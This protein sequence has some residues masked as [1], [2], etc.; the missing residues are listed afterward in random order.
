M[1]ENKR[2]SGIALI[3]VLALMA[4]LGVLAASAVAISSYAA[5]ETDTFT[6]LQR[7]IL[8]AE[9]VAN[10]TLFL[11]LSDRAKYADR[12]LGE[13]EVSAGPRFLADGTKHEFIVND[14]P[15]TVRIF[16]ATSGVDISGRNPSRQLSSLFPS[17][18]RNEALEVLNARLDD[19]A[20]NDELVRDRGMEA[21]HYRAAGIPELPR[22]R[23]M[24]FREELFWIPGAAGLFPADPAGRSGAVRLIAPEG[25]RPLSG[26]ASLYASAPEEIAARCLLTE[27]ETEQLK[28]AFEAW[29]EGR[30][31]LRETLP[32]GLLGKLEV[33]YSV[34]ESGA[35][36][37]VVDTASPEYP[38]CRLAV[39][40]RPSV[41]GRAIEYYEFIHY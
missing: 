11:L 8:E 30:K 32:P 34:R 23:P 3:T 18:E 31:P 13:P 40:V 37:I 38:G 20:D 21:P 28:Q 5:A 10:R 1:P 36:S 15:V 16:D 7:S 39:T 19:Y 24:Q 12:R 9:S 25:L 6:S 27:T 33:N 41:G 2:E 17:K 14:R 26:R 22:N 35:Y 4:T 29:R